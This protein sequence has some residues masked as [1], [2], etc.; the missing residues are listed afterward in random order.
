MKKN[1][2]EYFVY[3]EEELVSSISGEI[4]HY[5][6]Y[7][8]Q[9]GQSVADKIEDYKQ[10]CREMDVLPKF[11]VRRVGGALSATVPVKEK[12]EFNKVFRVD[13][14]KITLSGDLSRDELA[15][16]GMF[17]SSLRFPTNEIIVDSKHLTIE[18]MSKLMKIGRNGLA[19][20]IKSLEVRQVIK[21]VPRHMM[22]PIIYFNPFLV[23]TGRVIE[24][25]TYKMFKD[26]VYCP[27]NHADEDDFNIFA[28]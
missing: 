5:S 2:R 18:E 28:V 9:F 26:S 12:Y 3:N 19:K 15:F 24:Y 4:V 16:I 25:D 14:N 21:M 1:E 11:E 6:E 20:A 23:S 13:M 27:K 7:H 17:M 22:P 10:M 8:K